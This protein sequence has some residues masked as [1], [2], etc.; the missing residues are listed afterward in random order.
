[1]ALATF[2][3]V[4]CGPGAPDRNTSSEPSA[5]ASP[6]RSA[7]PVPT[8]STEVEST[9]G[10]TAPA[11]VPVNDVTLHS[12]GDVQLTAATLGKGPRGVVLL[13]QS[14]N[15][16]CGWLPYAGYLA[17]RGFH[18]LLF[19]RRCTGQSSCPTGDAANRHADD[20]QTA[21]SALHRRG[22][23]KVVLVGASLGGSVAI[24][25]CAVVKTDGCVAL[26]P[27][28][29]DLTLGNG[30]TAARAITKVRTPLLIADAPDDGD[31]PI[32]DVQA[33]ARRARP[34]VVQFVS[35][36]TGAG[37]GWDTVNDP[38]DPTRRSAFDARLLRFLDSHLS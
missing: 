25:A 13:H 22:A 35:L 32:S 4:A 20:V 26:S 18:V 33:L 6:A 23:Q 8:P 27:A 19:D 31:S 37:H 29:F 10:Q 21:V 14:D 36:P 1:M 9:C 7:D 11:S 30:L 3:L 16:I 28:I 24:G 15:G 2:L 34:G 17:S 12:G 38:T 5:A